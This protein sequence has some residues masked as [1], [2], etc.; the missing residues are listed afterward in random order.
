MS[1]LAAEIHDRELRTLIADVVASLFSQTERDFE[2][3]LEFIEAAELDRVGCFQ[4]SPVAGAAFR[5]LENSSRHFDKKLSS[6]AAEPAA[7]VTTPSINSNAG[8]KN[9]SFGMRS[10]ST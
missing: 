3:L 1:E 10:F 2:Q 5:S 8:M 7:I 4:Y 9:S 6:A